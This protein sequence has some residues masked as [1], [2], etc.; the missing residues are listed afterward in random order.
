MSQARHH[1]P[2]SATALHSA[3]VPEDLLQATEKALEAIAASV[4]AGR[5]K[6]REATDR[7]VGRDANRGKVRKHFEIDVADGGISWR[8]REARGHARPAPQG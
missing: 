7:R 2:N 3:V 4:R 1:G 6:G 8:R 5:L